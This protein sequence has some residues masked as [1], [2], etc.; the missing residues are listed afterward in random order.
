M[1]FKVESKLFSAAFVFLLLVLRFCSPE[2]VLANSAAP[3]HG[4]SLGAEPS[5]LEQIYILRETLNVDLRKLAENDDQ[6][7]LV[8]AIYDVENTGAEKKLE[9]IFAFGSSFTDFQILLDEREIDSQSLVYKYAPASWKTPEKTPWLDGNDFSYEVDS[10]SG[11]SQGFSL[12]MPAGKHRLKARYKAAPS[13]HAAN[14]MKY[15]QFTYILAPAREWAGF[16][17]LDITINAPKDWTV[18]TTPNLERDGETLKGS[19]NQIPADALALTAKAPLPILYEPLDIFL[20]VLWGAAIFAT[21]VF[22]A[23][24]AWK[25][26][27]KL[28]LSWLAGIGF[29]VLWTI[30]I[31]STG[32]LAGFG[33]GY[34][35]PK[36][37]L[38]SYG[39]VG[40][41]Y[42]F[43]SLI[44][45]GAAFFIGIALWFLIIYFAGKRKIA[46]A[47]V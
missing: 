37:Q 34:V 33:A 23:V 25:R 27:Y 24:F 30:L 42:I 15:W 9:L 11:K 17:G 3:T 36:N 2:D 32:F 22:I 14:P 35:I 18:V 46:K 28:K 7:I 5:G 38:S 10:R 29:A 44:A 4:G 41:L 43:G 47:F 6:T 39:Y 1:Q 19:F 40:I 8:E 12:I 13:Y 20:Q 31:I 21:P 45:G 26:G 16:G